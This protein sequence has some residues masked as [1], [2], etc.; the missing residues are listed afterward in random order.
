MCKKS[1]ELNIKYIKLKVIWIKQ[2]ENVTYSKLNRKAF[3]KQFVK[4]FPLNECLDKQD[5]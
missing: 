4:Q 1:L 2:S 3:Q 5:I